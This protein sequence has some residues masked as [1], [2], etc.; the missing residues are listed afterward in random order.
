MA[1]SGTNRSTSGG[2]WVTWHGDVRT[3]PDAGEAM[4]YLR[5][6]LR[7]L[8]HHPEVAAAT[9]RYRR[10]E[11]RV[12]FAVQ[13]GHALTPDFAAVR[14]ANALRES[15]ERAGFGIPDPPPGCAP[16]MSRVRLDRGPAA[17]QRA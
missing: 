7:S 2:Y 16:P 5:R 17:I 10:R 8:R 9:C 11:S 13:V 1:V 3:R 15:L 12:E 6:G 14:A 4:G